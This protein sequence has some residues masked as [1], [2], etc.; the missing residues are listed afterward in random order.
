MPST[1]FFFLKKDILLVNV[2]FAV[3]CHPNYSGIAKTFMGPAPACHKFNI[4][5]LYQPTFS[6]TQPKLF[7]NTLGGND[8]FVL[9]FVF[10]NGSAHF[11]I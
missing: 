4:H 3:C 6:K 5:I 11:G 10:R 8:F 1:L 7:S 2:L 9:F